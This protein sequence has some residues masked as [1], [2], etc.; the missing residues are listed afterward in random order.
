[1]PQ[2]SEEQPAAPQK[3]EQQPE[4]EAFTAWGKE[5]GGLQAGLALGKKRA[6]NQGKAV[7]LVVRVRNVGKE[8]VKF[9]NED[10]PRYLQGGSRTG[11][12]RGQI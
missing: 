7:T 2:A 10:R 1:L 6:Y 12:H 3:Q 5:V 9:R 11:G 8:A 4:K